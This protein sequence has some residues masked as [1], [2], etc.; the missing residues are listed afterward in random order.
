MSK[1]NKGGRRPV[2]QESG[3]GASKSQILA[4]VISAA[5]LL[6]ATLLTLFGQWALKPGERDGPTLR[7]PTASTTPSA[8][9]SP[10]A[11]T[12][13]PAVTPTV[14]PPAKVVVIIDKNMFSYRKSERHAGG[15]SNIDD[16]EDALKDLGV[17]SVPISTHVNWLKEEGNFRKVWDARP[18]LI[19]IHAS[20]F[21]EGL[22]PDGEDTSDNFHLFIADVMP[23]LPETKLLV[24]SRAFRALPESRI[25]KF[26]SEVKTSKEPPITFIVEAGTSGLYFRDG[27]VRQRLRAEVKKTLGLP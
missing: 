13:P 10:A 21:S 22:D 1:R 7:T 4:A 17:K 15:Q 26:V 12:P 5:G 3:G 11:E 16:I 9:T 23:K 20:A 19:I 24:Y 14:V 25:Q 8:S 2:T 6:T 18:D 27:Q